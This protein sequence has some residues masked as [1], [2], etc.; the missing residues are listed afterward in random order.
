MTKTLNQIFFLFLHQNQNIF[1]RNIGNQN[2]FLE[3]KHNPPPPLPFKLNGRSLKVSAFRYLNA[4][5]IIAN[6]EFALFTFSLYQ[7]L[8]H[9]LLLLLYPFL[10][11][12]ILYFAPPSCTFNCILFHYLSWQYSFMDLHFCGWNFNNH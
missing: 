1:F 9:Y 6:I 11:V 8:A 10:L 7:I 3:K 2:I 12:S 5:L 4:L